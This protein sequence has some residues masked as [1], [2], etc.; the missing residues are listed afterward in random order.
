MDTFDDESSE[1]VESLFINPEKEIT[2]PRVFSLK[3]LS[4]GSGS[5]GTGQPYNNSQSGNVS[6]AEQQP[7]NINITAQSIVRQNASSGQ[8]V[9]LASANDYST[10]VASETSLWVMGSKKYGYNK[11]QSPFYLKLLDSVR[12]KGLATGRNH[13]LLW[14]SAGQLYSWGF[15]H[16]GKLGHPLRPNQEENL[17]FLPQKIDFFN[18]KF[19]GEAAVS[20]SY[21][22]AITTSGDLYFWGKVLPSKVHGFENGTKNSSNVME[23]ARPKHILPPKSISSSASPFFCRVKSGRCHSAILSSS[24]TLYMLGSNFEG[25]LGLYEMSDKDQP[26]PIEEMKGE[27]IV[28]VACGDKFTVAI[29]GDKDQDPRKFKYIN[30]MKSNKMK[31]VKDMSCSVIQK[32]QAPE[33][34][35]GVSAEFLNEIAA[36]K[37]GLGLKDIPEIFR[38]RDEYLSADGSVNGSK[39]FSELE[40]YLGM[41]HALWIE[42]QGTGVNVEKEILEEV[43]KEDSRLSA[44]EILQQIHEKVER[45]KET[46]ESKKKLSQRLSQIGQQDERKR[47]V[48]RNKSF[49]QNDRPKTVENKAFR[50]SSSSRL[51]LQANASGVAGI[52]KKTDQEEQAEL[53]ETFV[54]MRYMDNKEKEEEFKRVIR[55]L[56]QMKR[57]DIEI[58]A[59]KHLKRNEKNKS[60]K[61]EFLMRQSQQMAKR[62][63]QT[64]GERQ[65]AHEEKM[66]Q[67]RDKLYEKSLECKQMQRI[68]QE[69]K[70][71]YNLW[72]VQW[73]NYMNMER[74]SQFLFE[75][76]SIVKSEKLF[77]I[78]KKMAVRSLSFFF[79]KVRVTRKLNRLPIHHIFAL[80]KLARRVKH[81]FE[82]MKRV[83]AME[84]VSRMMIF[85]E[86]YRKTRMKIKVKKQDLKV[87]SGFM[88][89]A[90]LKYVNMSRKLMM[91]WDNYIIEI[92]NSVSNDDLAVQ[93]QSIIKNV[94]LMSQWADSD[95]HSYDDFVNRQQQKKRAGAGK[96]TG[97]DGDNFGTGIKQTLK[98]VQSPPTKLAT[99]LDRQS[100]KFSSVDSRGGVSTHREAKPALVL[101]NSNGASQSGGDGS[102]SRN[103]EEPKQGNNLAELSD[104]AIFGSRSDSVQFRKASP[105]ALVSPQPGRRSAPFGHKDSLSNFLRDYTSPEQ[106][107]IELKEKSLL[108]F[109]KHREYVKLPS[110]YAFQVE[111]LQLFKALLD[112]ITALEVQVKKKI[113]QKIMHIVFQNFK[114]DQEDVNSPLKSIFLSLQHLRF[115]SLAFF[116]LI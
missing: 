66:V 89:F 97:A 87:I 29:L 67:L 73:I 101:K 10:F 100:F 11:F 106:Y 93:F 24:A 8:S 83:W 86:L 103:K 23:Q 14:D 61:K 50:I 42:A 15:A 58:K 46:E 26:F 47:E 99:L 79:R 2:E 78:R 75:R 43:L 65:R 105:V 19:V 6:V 36:Q 38:K 59:Q 60:Q 95:A 63:I 104:N 1:T 112:R 3:F 114:K 49:K 62:I 110:T 74:L 56:D 51:D 25:C 102:S 71:K 28:D 115:P 16:H 111:N 39:K 88:R 17:E 96:G 108:P 45:I 55:D 80:R 9:E 22:L 18:D 84:S 52:E 116:V 109:S 48:Q 68:I 90:L 30:Q 82:H 70:E 31:V 7:L 34:N 13:S 33:K 27:K 92:A 94:K 76:I 12:V 91:K 64:Q 4:G 5:S 85:N 44:R 40:Q 69:R 32:L 98:L 20:D 113:L 53:F 54:N 35:P 72:C 77:N 21:S 41:L 37:L 81:K 107:Q 57:Q